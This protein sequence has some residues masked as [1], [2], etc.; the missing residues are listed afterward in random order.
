MKV[1]Y[2]DNIVIVNYL[3]MGQN[4]QKLILGEILIK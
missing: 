1:F 3:N 4:N 2:V